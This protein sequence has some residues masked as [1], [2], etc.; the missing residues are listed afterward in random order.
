M[1][2]APNIILPQLV[3][4]NVRLLGHKVGLMEALMAKSAGDMY[5]SVCPLVGASIGQHI[6]HSMDHI[7]RATAATTT[8]YLT[9]RTP[10][11]N[12]PQ[13][14]PMG[15]DHSHS[16]QH[17]QNRETGLANIPKNDET[18]DNPNR[19][20]LMP[21]SNDSLEVHYDVRERGGLDEND[22]DAARQRIQTVLGSL[23][24][25]QEEC[26]IFQMDPQLPQHML[27]GAHPIDACFVL[28]C[29]PDSREVNL[30]STLSRELGFAAHHAIHHLAMIRII[31]LHHAGL[32]ADDLPSDFGRAPGT[33]QHD[34]TISQ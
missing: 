5:R 32:S 14:P 23:E 20:N 2:I 26:R 33:V 19:Y 16:H 34:H 24:E 1:L 27:R 29:D 4:T 25:L 6:R 22:M 18:D 8:A 11:F 28:E 10:G 12:P 31:A 15:H 30:P 13:R 17:D 7:E 9:P 21:P 3:R